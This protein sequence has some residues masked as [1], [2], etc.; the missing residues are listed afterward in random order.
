[1]ETDICNPFTAIKL[2]CDGET[3]ESIEPRLNI[4]PVRWIAWASAAGGASLA[5][6][7][8]S[9]AYKQLEMLD[10]FIDKA[11]QNW[12]RFQPE[13]RRMPTFT[14]YPEAENDSRH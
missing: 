8:G 4:K 11:L 2:I 6:V 9:E 14:S 10:N 13:T 3:F 12:Q 7:P 1:M 5:S